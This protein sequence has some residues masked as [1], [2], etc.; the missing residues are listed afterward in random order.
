[1]STAT[2]WLLVAAILLL[3]LF[4]A[5][6]V[7]YRRRFGTLLRKPVP[8]RA[9]KLSAGEVGLYLVFVL[10]LLFGLAA[11]TLAPGSAFALWLLEP[12]ARPVYFL[13]CF[14]GT[15]IV[16]IGLSVFSRRSEARGE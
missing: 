10:A 7:A 1:M 13:W 2:F 5:N 9:R 14:L 3:A 4:A 16:G 12:Y 8:V 6:A 15:V 11:P